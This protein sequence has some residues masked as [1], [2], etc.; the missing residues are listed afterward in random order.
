MLVELHALQ[1]H[2]VLLVLAHM[3]AAAVGGAR[4]WRTGSTGNSS[5]SRQHGQQRQHEQAARAA[6]AAAAATPP[7]SLT[8]LFVPGNTS[9]DRGTYPCFRQPELTLVGGDGLP[10]YIL[11][12]WTEA[13][14]FATPGPAGSCAP[15]LAG[16]VGD[17]ADLVYRRS[18]DAGISWGRMKLVIGNRTAVGQIDWYTTV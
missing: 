4:G 18:T 17:Q 13:Y 12:A 14:P 2:V 15:P 11:L 1:L 9:S 5:T 7:P 10:N 6:A 3:T 8:P 16:E